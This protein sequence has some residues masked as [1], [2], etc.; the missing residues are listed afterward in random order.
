MDATFVI[1]FHTQRF[2]NLLQTLRFLQSNHKD[3]IRDCQL[4][5]ICQDE[6]NKE[7]VAKAQL[8]TATMILN[9]DK[10][11]AVG[12]FNYWCRYFGR[13]DHYDMNVECMQ[14]PII[15]NFG[16]SKA[17]A[18]KI[19]L[20]ESDR[21]LPAGYFEEITR[22]LKPGYQWTTKNMWKLL[23]PTQDEQIVSKDFRHKDETRSLNAAIGMR[24]MWSGNTAFMKRD[25]YKA[26]QMDVEYKG[27]GWADNDMTLTMEKAGIQSMF[28]DEVLELHLWHPSATYDGKKDS[29]LLFVEN[30]VRFCEKW[31][32]PIP[33]WLQ[34]DIDNI[35][36]EHL[37]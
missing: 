3:F 24:S 4:V 30:G 10:S 37:L 27:Y 13:W 8:D 31:N 29:K 26:G 33:D 19:F 23:D 20:I 9:D 17:V 7:N 22:E 15:S 21:I 18:E 14:L 1:G 11:M 16:V 34:E 25:F 2:D 32:K 6:V 12:E 5:T 28:K 36:R 35:Q